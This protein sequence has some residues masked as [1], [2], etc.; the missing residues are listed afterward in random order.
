MDE[1]ILT[2]GTLFGFSKTVLVC[3]L[4]YFAYQTGK[5]LFSNARSGTSFLT[6]LDGMKFQITSVIV[7][8]ITLVT[9]FYVEPLLLRPTSVLPQENVAI[10]ETAKELEARAS[11]SIPPAKHGQELADM[12]DDLNKVKESFEALE[13]VDWVEGDEDEDA[14]PNG[15]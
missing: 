7:L 12:S 10:V 2:T 3:A 4:L 9:L 5:R 11:T 6:R 13:P 14:T 1:H 8:T 15:R